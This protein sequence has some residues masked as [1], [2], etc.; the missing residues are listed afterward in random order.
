MAL[1][2]RWTLSPWSRF[3]W[4][5]LV[6]GRSLIDLTRLASVSERV[7]LVGSHGA[8]FEVGRIL[9]FGPQQSSLLEVVVDLCRELAQG[10]AGVLIE[11]KPSSVAVHVRKARRD[12]AD[13][14]LE[15]VR[16]GPGSL[17]G[18][19][20]IEGKEVVELAVVPHG[21]GDAVDVLRSRWSATGTLFVGD[22]STDEAAFAVLGPGDLGIKVGE[23]MTKAEYR[24]PDPA[25]VVRMLERLAQ[26]RGRRG[27]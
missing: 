19:H 1:S 9:A 25:S 13:R 20:V 23:G 17:P 21:K 2:R 4:S 18:V 12:A 15:A 24:V 8:E 14:I 27:T 11:T 10:M 7:H 6:S 3:T 5:A 22:D 16:R 26:L